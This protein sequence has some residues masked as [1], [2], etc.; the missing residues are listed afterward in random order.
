MLENVC[1]VY[2]IKQTDFKAIDNKAEIHCP[3]MIL[4]SF[5]SILSLLTRKVHGWLEGITTQ[6]WNSCSYH[7][8]VLW[9]ERLKETTN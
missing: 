2:T 3:A 6:K 5:L 9:V 1:K 8:R 7:E 4:S